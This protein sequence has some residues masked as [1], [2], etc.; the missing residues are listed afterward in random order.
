MRSRLYECQVMHRRFAP[1]AH[2][3]RYR[4]FLFALDLDELDT[5]HQRLRLF[6]VGRA[7][8]YSFRD[9]DYL[10]TDEAVFNGRAGPLGP[11]PSSSARPAVA[12]YPNSKSASEPSA[13]VTSRSIL[14]SRVLAYL[15]AHGVEL[16]GG[17]VELITLPRVAGY[18]FNPVS[19]YFCYDRS[20]ECV[21][22]VPEVT[23]TFREM[24]P[25]F[26]GPDHRN[27]RS[28]ARDQSRESN[29]QSASAP[30]PEFSDSVLSPDS[31]LP[32]PASSIFRRRV[33]KHFYVS[34]FSDVDAAFDFTLRSPD[35]RLSIQIDD[36]VGDTRTLNSTL[37]GHARPLTDAALLA[38]TLRHPLVPLR[39]ISLIHWHALRLWL[40]RVPWFA[41]AARAADQRGL[42]RP[43][44][45]LTQPVSAA[46][47]SSRS[48]TSPSLLKSQI[49][50]LKFPINATAHPATAP[51]A[52]R[53]DAA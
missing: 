17:R 30:S 1:K 12:P 22:A 40:K 53:P 26:L 43:H 41:K 37:T 20:G 34:P 6:S 4:I 5:L 23:N 2:G 49:S 31:C 19:F 28:E 47:L 16:A 24:K 7:N 3:F 27:Q 18:L 45:S 48:A 50:D 46:P 42:Y 52:R 44:H 11:P 13:P 8:L 51:L 38:L 33:A 36:Y 39:T 29:A 25:F 10:P 32:S 14:K 21:A 9:G 35:D 15:A